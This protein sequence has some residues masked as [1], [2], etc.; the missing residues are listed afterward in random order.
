[1]LITATS[2][3]PAYGGPAYSVASLAAAL[4]DA[5]V[6]V[7]LW[8]ADASVDA[9]GAAPRAPLTR[10]QGPL[11]DTVPGFAPTVIHDNGLWRP[12]NHR[13]ADLARAAGV[14]RVVSTR[15][16][17]EPWAF[18]HKR[19]KKT[20]AWRLYQRRDLDSAAAL[21]ATAAEEGENL[22][23]FALRPPI[24]TIANGVDLPELPPPSPGADPGVRTAIFLGRIYPVKGLLMLIEAWARVRPARW[25]LIIAGPDEAGHRRAVEAAVAAH[26]LGEAVSFPGPV[27]GAAK[28]ALMQ[29]A[30]LMVAPSLSESFGMAIAEALAYRVPVLT[31]T[32]APWPSLEDRGCGWRAA[33]TADAFARALSVATTS[34]PSILR[35]M[36]EAGRALVA[37]EYGWPGIAASFLTLYD[38]LARQSGRAKAAA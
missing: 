17:L 28:A 18:R 23:S 8:A 1:V 11:R 32:A 21:H 34:D 36:G 7:G 13:I 24:R 5:G 37:A 20:A 12:H 25:R 30:D 31:T 10:L 19:W 33:P 6:A 15:G 27:A 26:G 4:A 35:T 2:L 9:P 22:R 3:R 14:P 16:M 38:E 29:D